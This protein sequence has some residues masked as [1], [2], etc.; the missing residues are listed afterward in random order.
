[1]Q[2]MEAMR[3]V[4]QHLCLTHKRVFFT[5]FFPQKGVQRDVFSCMTT[6]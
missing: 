1:M 2:I 3:M 5:H 6:A 4:Y